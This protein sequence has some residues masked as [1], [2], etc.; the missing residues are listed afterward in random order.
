M[1]QKRANQLDKRCDSADQEENVFP[2]TKLEI[3]SLFGFLAN[4][5]LDFKTRGIL[6]K[7]GSGDAA[8]PPEFTA[9]RYGNVQAA[10]SLLKAMGQRNVNL[11]I[12]PIQFRPCFAF[13]ALS[14][15]AALCSSNVFLIGIIYTFSLPS[16]SPN[17]VEDHVFPLASAE[18]IGL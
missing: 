2:E 8:S 6:K 13:D 5:L 16:K 4:L 12:K 1:F 9:R 15:I 7:A 10:S 11:V 17:R 3:P 18:S 14:I